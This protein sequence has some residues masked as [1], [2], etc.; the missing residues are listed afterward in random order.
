VNSPLTEA[1]RALPEEIAR[2]HLRGVAKDLSLTDADLQGVYV[3]KQYRTDHNGVTHI[4]FRQRF[5]G[6]DVMNA[7]W[8]V[9]LDRD[10]RVLNAGGNL[11]PAPKPG[12]VLPARMRAF[13]AVRAAVAAVNE[14]LKDRFAPFESGEPPQKSSTIRFARGPLARDVEGAVVWFPH[15]GTLRPAWNFLVADADRVHAYSVTVDE[16]SQNILGKR[17]LTLFQQAQAT[18][19]P[20]TPR[21]MVFDQESPQPDPTPGVRLTGAPPIVPRVLKGFQ[22]DPVA[23]PIGWTDGK[24][25]SGNNVIAGE[26]L[27]GTAFLVPTPTQGVNGEF[28]FPLQLGAGFYPL[29]YPDAAVTNLFYWANRA[30]DLHYQYGFDEQSGNFQAQNFGRGGVGGD[31]MYA[32]AHYG[33]QTVGIGQFQNSFF[34]L[35]GTTDDGG[36]PEISMFVSG[37]LGPLGDLFTDGSYDAQV[38]VHEYTHGVSARLARQLYNTFQ[39]SA[40][41]EAFSDFYGLEYTVPD[42]APPDGIYPIGQYFDQ[43]WGYGGGR[44][45]PYSTN[46]DVDPLTFANIGQ[47]RSSPEVHA[48]GE[49]W[50]EAMW[51]ARANLIAQFGETEGRKRVRQ[52]VMD[53]MK[54]A[55]PQASMVD[56]RDAILLADRVDYKGASQSQLWAGFAKRGLG[57][58]A[59]SDGGSTIHV[60]PSFD[61]PSTTGQLRFY[62]NPIVIGEVLRVVLQDSNNADPTAHIQLTGSSGDLEDLNLRRQGSIFVGTISTGLAAVAKGNLR[63]EVSSTDEVSAY[64]VDMDTG[65]GSAKLIQTTIQT[66]L[67]YALSTSAASLTI[68]SG[69]TKISLPSGSV[70]IYPLPFSFP[71]YDK[72]FGSANVYSNGLIAFDTP[73]TTNSCTDY[74]GLTSYYGISPLWTPAAAT[75]LAGNA[76]PNEGMYISTAPGSVTFRWAGEYTAFGQPPSPTAFAVTLFDDGRIQMNY[77]NNA[78][79]TVLLPSGFSECAPP[80]AGLANGH[81]T[82]S[83]TFALT[84][85]NNQLTLHFD[86]PYHNGSLPTATVTRPQAGDHVQDILTVSGT[87]ADSASFV[88]MVD[89]LIDGINRAHLVPAGA[90]GAWSTTLDIGGLGLTP[91]NHTVAIRATNARGGFANL[92]ASPIPFT[93]DP[94]HAFVPTA[95]IEQPADGATITG[96]LVVKGY[97]YDSGLRVLSVDTLIDG[98]VFAGTSYNVSR[99]DIC[100]TLTPAPPNCPLIGFTGTFTT[101][102]GN[103]P[104]P[105][106]Q[107]TLQVRVRDQTG[108]LTL[109]PSTPL[110]ITV[111][112]GAAAPVIG[113]LEA[114]ASNAKVSGTITVSG[115]VYSAGHKITSATVRVD[116]VTVGTAKLGVARPD[117]CP[118]LPNADACPNI[119]FTF[120]LNTA[121]FL[122]GPHILGIRAVNDRGD[123]AV[124]PLVA[125]GGI[126]IFVQN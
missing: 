114:P 41:G 39:G 47:V 4:V 80:S 102:E 89:V 126:T 63:V 108:R 78:N 123:Y 38:M 73:V 52:L 2:Q 15:R 113:V 1:S 51:E 99:T 27:S 76:Q 46:M 67:P 75:T 117:V 122:N 98:F 10:G 92:P 26:N 91:G 5:G 104:I 33:A 61:L 42:G 81:D 54:L 56:M 96:P 109:Y 84:T 103:P 69:E 36:Q 88:T 11:Y 107:H 64:Y 85:Y 16:E 94:G 44:T 45:H 55:V 125:N 8:V 70:L 60:L 86:P 25:T 111:K 50:V 21:G 28:N 119:G 20:P 48:D 116:G 97:A 71:F 74:L 31:A 120:T 106:G 124:F 37:G 77:G 49:I 105:D 53:G 83:A 59:Y 24:A 7:E 22:G 90:T 87:A 95:A 32:Y 101:V 19:P 18:T 14:Q 57:A 30:H 43:S 110:N 72:T 118:S 79:Q 34:Q 23:S 58:L 6:G 66:M 65:N 40:M 3:A 100:G 12:R 93:V 121:Q 62:D 29:N 13:T 112:N 68:P 82:Y 35:F 115:Y 9:N 17:P